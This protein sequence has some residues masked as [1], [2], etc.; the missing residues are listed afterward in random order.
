MDDSTGGIR[1]VLAPQSA[2][3]CLVPRSG[4]PSPLERSLDREINRSEGVRLFEELRPDLLIVCGAPI[5]KSQ[6][7]SIPTIGAV[8]LHFGVAPKYRGAEHAFLGALSP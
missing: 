2:A 4:R 8:N 5:L 7:F 6:V 3:S 1:N